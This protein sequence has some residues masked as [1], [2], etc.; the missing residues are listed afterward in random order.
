MSDT[1]P[2]PYEAP[3]VEEIDGGGPIKTAPIASVD[4]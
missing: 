2:Q 1:N 4:V 3:T